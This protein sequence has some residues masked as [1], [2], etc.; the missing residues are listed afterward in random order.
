MKSSAWQRFAFAWL[1]LAVIGFGASS[2][3]SA[4]SPK[5]EQ[6]TLDQAIQIAMKTSLQRQMAQDDVQ[7]AKEKLAQ[8]SSAYGPKLT[9][10]GM[11]NHYDEQPALVTVSTGLANLA[12][13]LGGSVAV[14][15]DG[16]DYYGYQIHLEQPLYTGNKLTATHRQAKANLGNAASN[17]SAAENDLVLE[18]KKAYYTVLLAAQ[19]EITMEEAVSSMENHVAEAKSYCKAGMVPR[20][21]IMRAE[22][23]LADLKQ[24]Q[25]MA[26]NNLRLAKTAFNYTLGVNLDTVYVLK[27]QMSYKPLQEQLNSC[28]E[29][30]LTYRPE[31]VAMK[32]KIEMAKQAVE[33][34]KSGY[35][36]MV[37]L[38]AEK[39]HYEPNDSNPTLIMGVV[40]TVK[41]YD[42]GMVHH[43]I[44]EAEDNLKKA[45][46]G[47]ELMERAVKLEV[48]QAYHNVEAALEAIAVAEE[49]QAQARETLHMADTS[50]KAGVGTSL[51]RI[52]AEVGLTQTQTNYT[53]ALS[54]YSIAMA[55]LARAMGIQ[56]EDFQ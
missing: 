35:K 3:S 36:P 24:K 16:L 13:K 28:Q 51:E 4:E 19:M 47:Q 42:S 48:E 25:L 30:A 2:G 33:I 39:H 8:S 38:E 55:Q 17:L 29:N 40:A 10:S 20:I 22:V 23:K 9:L 18:V 6:L 54:M 27:D 5:A 14:P 46:T 44:V 45:T 52:D 7:A 43:Q 56:K 53:H 11:Y 50:Y 32:A 41:L 12:N 15:D 34:A 31:L 21:D 1:I 37:A 49:S 26:K